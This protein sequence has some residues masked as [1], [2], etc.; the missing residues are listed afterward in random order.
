MCLNPQKDV[1]LKSRTFLKQAFNLFKNYIAY[2]QEKRQ[3]SLNSNTVSVTLGGHPPVISDG[4]GSSCRK[5]VRGPCTAHSCCAKPCDASATCCSHFSHL[6]D[7][8][9]FSCFRCIA[10]HPLFLSE[11][12]HLLLRRR[13]PA[14][15]SPSL[16][17]SVAREDKGLLNSQSKVRGEQCSPWTRSLRTGWSPVSAVPRDRRPEQ[18][19]KQKHKQKTPDPQK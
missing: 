15:E 19:Q 12:M 9:S 10:L 7:F 17:C 8:P 18:A 1:S 11:E 4:R 6:L 3:Y 14:Q 5:W 2:H 16:M 13:P